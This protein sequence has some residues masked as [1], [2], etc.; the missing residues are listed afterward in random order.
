MARSRKNHFSTS[1]LGNEKDELYEKARKIVIDSG[2]P[3]VIYI[4]KKLNIGYARS[5]RLL[6]ELYKEGVV[7]GANGTTPRKVLVKKK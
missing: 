6:D 7:S 5:A 3:S 4:Q 2:N 1:G